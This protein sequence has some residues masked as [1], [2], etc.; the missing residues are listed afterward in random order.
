MVNQTPYSYLP[1][2]VNYHAQNENMLFLSSKAEDTGL[3][4]RMKFLYTVLKTRL[5][6]VSKIQISIS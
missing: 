1:C 6:S 5:T 4:L 3:Q 2:F